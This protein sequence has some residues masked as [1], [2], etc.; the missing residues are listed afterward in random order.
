MAKKKPETSSEPEFRLLDRHEAN[1]MGN[2]AIRMEK[3]MGFPITEEE[4]AAFGDR[5]GVLEIQ[6]TN[7]KRQKKDMQDDYR[8]QINER[9]EEIN[10]IAK[11]MD[12]GVDMR[13]GEVLVDMDHKIKEV[14]TYDPVT[15][16]C[17]ERRTMTKDEIANPGLV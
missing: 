12:S 10:K 11:T 14:R 17:L 8:G 15:K 6:E 4:R 5:L 3:E 7:L 13:L 9:R 1:P 16:A 2:A